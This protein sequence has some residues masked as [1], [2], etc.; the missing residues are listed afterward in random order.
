MR[1]SAL[2]AEAPEVL[3]CLVRHGFTPLANPAMRRALAPT[4][5]LA[6]AVRLRGLSEAE[7]ASLYAE[8]RTVCPCR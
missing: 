7:A 4:I 2:L 8:L 5:T 1:V 3:P 6:Q